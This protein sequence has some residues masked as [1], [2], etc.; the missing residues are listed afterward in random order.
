MQIRK[1]VDFQ[2]RQAKGKKKGRKPKSFENDAGLGAKTK[3]KSYFEEEITDVKNA[4]AFRHQPKSF[5]PGGK[6][7]NPKSEEGGFK[8][9]GGTPRS[10]VN[11]SDRKFTQKM[12]NKSK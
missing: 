2:K 1:L 11:K 3:K 5:K 7:K 9:K 6:G 8:K 12:K 10:N 4:R